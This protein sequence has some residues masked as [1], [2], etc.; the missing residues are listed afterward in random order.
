MTIESK[1][2]ALIESLD[3]NTAALIGAAGSDKPA[4]APKSEKQAVKEMAARV[5]ATEAAAAVV[6][7]KPDLK[8]KVA[9]AIEAM[10][11][12]NKR[13]EAIATLASFNDSKSASGIIDQGDEVI[14]AFLEAADGV[15]LG[16]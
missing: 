1:I 13:K 5:A 12:A 2:D 15:L 9:K 11:K 6:E 16:A 3:K 14:A 4:K 8:D 7:P 10:L